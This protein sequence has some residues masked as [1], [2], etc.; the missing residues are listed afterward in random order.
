MKEQLKISVNADEHL[1]E[2][3][4][5]KIKSL[6]QQI[7]LFKKSGHKHLFC[8]TERAS[9]DIIERH[10]HVLHI[11]CHVEAKDCEQNLHVIVKNIIDDY[12]YEYFIQQPYTLTKKEFVYTLIDMHKKLII[13]LMEGMK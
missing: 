7:T 10:A 5:N 13:E 8:T 9:V 4:E 2:Y 6:E 3:Y 11:A 1:I 12:K